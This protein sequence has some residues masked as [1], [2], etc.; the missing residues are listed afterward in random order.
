M[1]ARVDRIQGAYKLVVTIYNPSLSQPRTV[2]L[3]DIF[4]E[5]KIVEARVDGDELYIL[6]LE[7]AIEFNSRMLLRH[8][9]VID[10]DSLEVIGEHDLELVFNSTGYKNFLESLHIRNGIVGIMDGENDMLFYNLRTD[11]QTLKTENGARIV[12]LSDGMYI[13]RRSQEDEN[14][15]DFNILD[16]EI[17]ESPAFSLL[18]P[19]VISLASFIKLNDTEVFVFGGMRDAGTMTHN[20]DAYVV[21]IQTD[22]TRHIG[23]IPLKINDP[24]QSVVVGE[25]II[26]MIAR[27]DKV[28][29]IGLLVDLNKTAFKAIYYPKLFHETKKLLYYKKFKNL[30][31]STSILRYIR[32]YMIDHSE[33]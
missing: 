29:D 19:A 3:P 11:W 18:L 10:M 5:T 4:A 30:N 16:D 14:R 23:K 22:E 1:I 6:L 33:S 12:S 13:V 32:S 20:H 26:Y 21:N 17:N 27:D 2:E 28:E 7:A 31:V 8:I 9:I 25:R 15:L 24:Y